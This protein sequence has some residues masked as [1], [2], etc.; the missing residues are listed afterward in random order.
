MGLEAG[1]STV[2]NPLFV[3]TVFWGNTNLHESTLMKT[4][5]ED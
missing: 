4:I 3:A 2:Q 1:A 5:S